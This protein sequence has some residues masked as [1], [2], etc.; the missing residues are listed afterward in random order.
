MTL[1]KAENMETSSSLP[2]G[3][4]YS[5][6]I[7]VI[8]EAQP[9]FACGTRSPN[10]VIQLRMNNVDI[11]GNFVWKEY[12]RVPSECTDLDKYQLKSGD[13][14]FN[15][16]NSTELVGK[17]ALFQRYLEP[18]VYS[19][20][21]TRIRVNS[22]CASPAYVV[23][24]INWQYSCGT[25]ANLCNRWIGQSAVKNEILFNLEILL[26][27]TLEEQ[28]RIA[29]TLNK[30]M[31]A[32]EK[33]R[34]ATEARLAT[35]KAL[36]AAYL[37]EVF[38]SKQ[39]QYWSLIRLRNA[40]D[41]IDYGYTASSDRN[42]K[43]PRFLR[44]TDIQ[45]GLVDW[46]SVPGCKIN[47]T[48]EKTNLLFNGDIVFARTGGTVGKSYLITN[49]PRAVFASYLIRLRPK[50]TIVF[51]E[52]LYSFF[53]SDYYWKQLRKSSRGG[54][55]PNVNATLLGNLELPVPSIPQQETLLLTL[56]EKMTC[57]TKIV[58]IAEAEMEAINTLPGALL[59]QAFSGG[60]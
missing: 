59:R 21:F 36:S 32:V 22:E 30:Q 47:E 51:P 3:W 10:G 12:L 50:K 57:A 58:T 49:P 43:E 37:R 29:D 55:Q 25:F 23:A 2:M 38:E 24:W 11:H 7:D 5:K 13:I 54:A 35:A 44:I 56:R 17:S 15:N 9:G 34:A 42:I 60:L 41:Q 31:A 18:V 14:L 28:K 46:D 1:T 27:T 20:H 33:A 52:Y 4:H 6:L 39:A 45:N 19:N 40:C 48:E 8:A 53:Q 16:T 26:P